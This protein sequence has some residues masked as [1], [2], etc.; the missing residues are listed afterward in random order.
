MRKSGTIYAWITFQAGQFMRI[1]PI[2]FKGFF[3]KIIRLYE[4]GQFMR[5]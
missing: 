5:G 2:V 4:A 3:K 1:K